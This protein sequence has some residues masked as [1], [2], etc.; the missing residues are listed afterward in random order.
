M[1]FNSILQIAATLLRSTSIIV[2]HTF[3]SDNYR[4]WLFTSSSSIAC[5]FFSN[6]STS[7]SLRVRRNES[8]IYFKLPSE[9]SVYLYLERNSQ[10][11][12]KTRQ[13]PSEKVTWVSER[14]I[15][16]NVKWNFSRARRVCITGPLRLFV[17]AKRNSALIFLFL[18]L[19]NSIHCVT[20]ILF[21]FYTDTYASIEVSSLIKG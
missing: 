6:F 21:A 1:S 20:F 15:K 4:F 8:A 3:K 2:V 16:L 18:V 10:L 13:L 11:E 5:D 12:K 19:S 7:V 17:A 14:R 9:L